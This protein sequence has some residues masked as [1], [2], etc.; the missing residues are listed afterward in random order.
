MVQ[1]PPVPFFYCARSVSSALRTSE[2]LVVLLRARPCRVQGCI[3]LP[4]FP[5]GTGWVSFLILRAILLAGCHLVR[6]SPCKTRP[7]A[8]PAK[9]RVA[10]SNHLVHS[11]PKPVPPKVIAVHLLTSRGLGV[12]AHFWGSRLY[13]VR[14]APATTASL[15]PGCYPGPCIS[16]S[17][18]YLLAQ[19][20]R[21][22]VTLGDAI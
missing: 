2:P 20:T 19:L 3:K 5:V 8:C 21:G 18:A 15:A 9:G 14:L 6:S 22:L 11:L 7:P 4:A 13:S 16:R 1:G 17:A 10:R 12:C